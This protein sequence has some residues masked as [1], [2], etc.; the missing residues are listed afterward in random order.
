MASLAVSPAPS[1][2]NHRPWV[3]VGDWGLGIGHCALGRPLLHLGPQHLELLLHVADGLHDIE[4]G[5]VSCRLDCV[6]AH[7]MLMINMYPRDT[8]GSGTAHR[9]LR[10]LCSSPG[11]E[12]LRAGLAVIARH[13]YGLIDHHIRLPW[14]GRHCPGSVPPGWCLYLF[15]SH[16]RRTVPRAVAARGPGVLG[17]PDSGAFLPVVPY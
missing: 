2:P 10:T 14:W 3:V 12:V 13:A 1:W 7:A 4:I 9:L 8:I 6:S 5:W 17:F 11:A 16:P 15:V